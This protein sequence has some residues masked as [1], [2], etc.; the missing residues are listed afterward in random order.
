MQYSTNYNLNLVEGTD[1]VNPLVIDKPNY[2]T[3]D[4]Q[5]KANEDSGVGTA[6]EI[7]TGT[8]H[9]LTRS[10]GDNNVF[11]YVA[12]SV[13]NAGD[14]F[15]VDGVN[16]TALLPTGEA[17]ANNS[18]AIGCNVLAILTSTELTIFTG[19]GTASNAAM[20]NN[21]LPSYYLDGRN[22]SFDNTSTDLTATNTEAAIKEVNTKADDTNKRVSTIT[23]LP[24][25]DVTAYT[26]SNKYTIPCDGYVIVRC[27]TSAG[28][29]NQ[30]YI[31]TSGDIITVMTSAPA[32]GI[33]TGNVDIPVFVRTGMKVY[34]HAIAGAN[35][36][37][38]FHPLSY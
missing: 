23:S 16:V 25:V 38:I 33:N 12:T 7:K 8:V 36:K 11:R 32:S 17:L 18:Y 4:T 9:A 35:S 34:T 6:T 14:T 20:L 5:M 26:S 24:T 15:T 37:T 19:G 30:C 29:Y 22:E 28:S 10:N 3:I 31:D 13:C 21:Q 1:I 27:D 2:I